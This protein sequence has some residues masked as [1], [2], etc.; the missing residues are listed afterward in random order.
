MT[1]TVIVVNPLGSALRHYSEALLDN[2]ARGGVDARL[3]VFDE[4]SASGSGALRW[5]VAYWFAVRRASRARPDSIIVAWP[6]AGYLDLALVT[7]A[8]PGV[9]S[10]LIVHDPRPLVRARG[11]GRFG[12]F[13]ARVVGR[14]RIIVHSELARHDVVEDT[15][16]T[17]AL[18]PHPVL[19]AAP[20]RPAPREAVVR[21][22][23]QFKRDRDVAMLESL[24]GELQGE[25][26][27]EVHG[28]GWPT[29]HGWS[30]RDAFV[31]EVELDELIRSSVAVLIPYRRFYQS[32]IAVRS[33]E[34]GTP[35]IGPAGSSLGDLGADPAHLPDSTSDDAAVRARR[36]AAAV[37]AAAEG[38]GV[39]LHAASSADRVGS[40]WGGALRG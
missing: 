39:P 28:R 2:L 30:V 10:R 18:L 40:V 29:V 25:F 3:I 9:T 36:W 35:F 26:A 34:V 4:P 19:P 5:L 1:R 20:A 22:L 12:Q 15:G 24:A 31:E 27:L 11:S 6:V 14:G 21:V 16:V 37:R 33:L 17:P 32:G 13:V 8:A 38:D 7:L 23:G